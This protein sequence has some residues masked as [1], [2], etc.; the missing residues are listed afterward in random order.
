MAGEKRGWKGVWIWQKAQGGECGDRVH[1]QAQGKA[2][3]AHRWLF[4]ELPAPDKMQ[5]KDQGAQASPA[6]PTCTARQP[7]YT[8]AGI[9]HHPQDAERNRAWTGPTFL[10]LRY[11]DKTVD[12]TRSYGHSL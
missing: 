4:F 6:L 2:D 3:G 5:G 8:R 10:G 11:Q 1:T 9:E 12:I 7:M